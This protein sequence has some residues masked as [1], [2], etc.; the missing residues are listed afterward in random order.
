MSSPKRT[1]RFPLRFWIRRW[2]CRKFHAK[3]FLPTPPVYSA[4]TGLTDY[5]SK[6]YKMKVIYE[7]PNLRSLRAY[8]RGRL[9]KE[10]SER[11]AAGLSN[12]NPNANPPFAG[13]TG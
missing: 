8:R 4:K 1:I 5:C 6:C 11:R 3:H 2:F 9:N 13:P 12:A 7:H 10:V